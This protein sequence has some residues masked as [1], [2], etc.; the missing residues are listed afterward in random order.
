MHLDEI[1]ITEFNAEHAEA[2]RDPDEVEAEEKA[3][4]EKRQ[5][6]ELAYRDLRERSFNIFEVMN[7]SETKYATNLNLGRLDGHEDIQVFID[8]EA[9]SYSGSVEIN[10]RMV[11]AS[12]DFDMYKRSIFTLSLSR[13]QDDERE[14]VTPGHERWSDAVEIV[15]ALEA[16]LGIGGTEPE[17]EAT[18]V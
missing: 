8:A 1:L 2:S 14:K 15:E 4:R 7:H 11:S 6:E 16:H 5:A 17:P 3:E 10:L 12:D 13:I 18:A 9:C